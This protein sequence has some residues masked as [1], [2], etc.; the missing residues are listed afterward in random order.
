[1]IDDQT[2][3]LS[4]KALA[5][6]RLKVPSGDHGGDLME[7]ESVA[8]F[9]CSEVS[10]PLRQRE[11]MGA[12]FLDEA[13]N[14]VAL[15][16]PYRGYLGR[17]RIEPHIILTP[18]MM[19]GGTSLIVFHNRPRGRRAA[20]RRDASIA[21]QVRDACELMGLRLLDYLVIGAGGAWTSLRDQRRV[22]F[23]SLNGDLPLP[24]NDG[25][26]RVQPKY[27]NPEPPHQT[28]SGRGKMAKWLSD[29]LDDDDGLE[30]E[31]FAIKE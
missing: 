31:D 11:H 30:L 13:G 2:T 29:K 27:R 10:Q 12:I 16:V 26:A 9:L 21:R 23:H 28:W 7:P 19:V 8:G 14:P 20:P 22:R 18:A 5:K 24:G 15:G 3:R 6:Q 17:V 25:R 1:M 4:R